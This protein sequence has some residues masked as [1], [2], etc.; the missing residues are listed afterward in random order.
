MWS[1]KQLSET[2]GIVDA[3][4]WQ[5]EFP[6][7]LQLQPLWSQ[8]DIQPF[9]EYLDNGWRYGGY[10]ADILRAVVHATPASANIAEG[11]LYCE[12]KANPLLITALLIFAKDD[13]F[14]HH[15][16]TTVISP[17]RRKHKGLGKIVT[18][19]GFSPSGM[20]MW[21]GLDGNDNLFETDLY[22][23]AKE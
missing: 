16:I 19:A 20:Q 21:A 3:F 12:R 11:H 18:N 9:T 2:E 15:G 14:R 1:F 13:L 4:I 8:D 5:H 7:W 17:I 23:T 6:K 10:E 22:L